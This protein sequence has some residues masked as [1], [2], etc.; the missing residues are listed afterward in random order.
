MLTRAKGPER[1]QPREVVACSAFWTDLRGLGQLP[2]IA[3]VKIF[4]AG[5]NEET[6]N[7]NMPIARA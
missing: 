7:K 6:L 1:E 3:Q 2:F 5:R 4:G